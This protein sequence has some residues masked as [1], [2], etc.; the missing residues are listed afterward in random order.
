MTGQ[1]GSPRLVVELAVNT[2]GLLAGYAGAAYVLTDQD[3]EAVSKG[4]EAI[5]WTTGPTA[6]LKGLQLALEAASALGTYRLDVRTDSKIL[7]A[8]MTGA[9]SVR[10]P[11]LV[12]L[13]SRAVIL[14]KRFDAVT[15]EFALPEQAS[16]VW[17]LAFEAQG[18]AAGYTAPN[19]PA[20]PSSR[21]LLPVGAGLGST[22]RGEK[23]KR[24]PHCPKMISTWPPSWWNHAQT[25][26]PEGHPKIGA[27]RSRPESC[28]DC[29][30]RLITQL[31]HDQGVEGAV[32]GAYDQCNA[33]HRRDQRRV[34]QPPGQPRAEA[35][36]RADLVNEVR[37]LMSAGV[38]DPL[39]QAKR[40]GMK[41]LSF[42]RAVC[43]ARAA[44]QLPPYDH[45]LQEAA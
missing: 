33:C 6:R 34:L 31:Q 4:A 3:G 36:R 26:E 27:V 29:H 45:R 18:K 20:G 10:K 7:L 13:H 1:G 22:G 32:H 43:R 2:D 12:A 14:E 41:P 24:C 25:H 16:I 40:L 37:Q 38:H 23:T 39:V 35:Y 9:T 44:G 5:G 21:R 11:E 19:T 42:K 8:Q 17:R 30:R 15:Y 28:R